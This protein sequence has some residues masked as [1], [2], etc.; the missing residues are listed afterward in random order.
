MIK[1]KQY[2]V[3][4]KFQMRLALE[5]MVVVLLVPLVVWADFYV[6]GQYALAQNAAAGMANSSWGVIGALIQRQWLL[7]VVVYL[8]NFGLIYLFIIFYTHRIAGPVYRFT[9][10]LTSMAG[11]DLSA[12]IKLRKN[13]YFENLGESINRLSDHYADTF[14][15]LQ[16][17]A[18]RLEEQGEKSADQDAKI[19]IAKIKSI[20]AGYQ[21]GS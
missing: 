5:L 2:L 9:E 8:V 14:R 15:E 10:T 18:S 12:R 19:Q 1:R 20:L 7:M 16:A 4:R 17:A 11:G 3:D 13:D 6:L 21:T